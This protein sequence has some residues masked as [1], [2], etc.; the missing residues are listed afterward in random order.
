MAL[1]ADLPRE[2]VIHDIPEEEE[3]ASRG[4]K[5]LVK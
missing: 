3:L 5:V 4:R 1:A 2:E